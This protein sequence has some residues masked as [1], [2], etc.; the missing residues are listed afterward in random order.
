VLVK[1]GRPLLLRPGVTLIGLL[2][3]SAWTLVALSPVLATLLSSFK[4]ET[5]II[6]DPLAWP[7]HILF[8]NYERAWSGTGFALPLWRYAIN[9]LVAVAVG[10]S[11]AT[12]TGT[13]CAYALARNQLRI[14]FLN[15][16]FV[17]LLTV[18]AT[19][20]W[21]PL[22][23]LAST[24]GM[25]SSP[26]ALGVIYSAFSIPI[27]VLLMRAY[28][29]TFPLDLIDAAKVDGASERTAFRLIVLPMSLGA[30]FTVGLIQAISM[31]NELALAVILLLRGDSRTLPVGLTALS[32]EFSSDFGAQFASLILSIIPMIGLYIIAERR[33]LAGMRLGALK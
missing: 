9:S 18:P 2:V 30:I 29:S 12:F 24:L 16:Y 31:W 22:F 6:A 28:F 10:V 8:G 5:A 7:R 25:L 32:G 11:I 21:L 27:V 23:S 20:T 17:L 26:L 1:S 13:L 4:D 19:V 3:V 33:I 14:P 15:K